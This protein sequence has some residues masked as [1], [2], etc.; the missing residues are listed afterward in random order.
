MSHRRRKRPVMTQ[1]RVFDICNVLLTLLLTLIVL[2]PVWNIIVIS[3]SSTEAIAEGKSFLWPAEFSLA[4]YRS[5]L[6]DR[7]IGRAFW[8]SIAKTVVSVVMHTFC[9]SMMGFAMSK[10]NL[11]GRKFYTAIGLITM[12]FS[13][14]M[15]PTYLVIKRLGLLNNFWVYVIPTLLDYYDIVILMNFF[16]QLPDSL[17]ESARIDGAGAWKVLLRIAMPLSKPVLATIALCHGVYQWNE[18]MAAKLYIQN[19]ALY[20]MQMKIYLLLTQLTS[21]SMKNAAADV[22][23]TSS[24]GTNMAA[25]IV[26]TVPIVLI[27]PF[28]QRYFVTGIM[29]GAVKE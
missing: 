15:I 29:I 22:G 7:S 6:R 14:G 21:A 19:S 27:Y 17:E 3:F 28:L 1:S 12:F 24:R 13:G 8:V 18:F 11:A 10:E 5:V 26:A 23:I 4:N 20:S 9:C 2:I 25:V 16:R